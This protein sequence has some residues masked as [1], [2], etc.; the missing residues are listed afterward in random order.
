MVIVTR[1]FLR[2]LVFRPFTAEDYYG[3]AGV[4]SPVPMIAETQERLVVIDG[5]HCEVYGV[6]NEFEEPLAVVEDITLL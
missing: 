5:V 3:F 2:S 1:E 4:Q 6:E